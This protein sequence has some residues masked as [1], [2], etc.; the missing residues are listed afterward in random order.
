MKRLLLI[1]DQSK[2][3]LNAKDVAE[4]LGMQVQ[5]KST[6][7][8]ARKFLEQGLN[9]EIP[10]PEVIVLDLD[11]GQDSGFEL[12]RFRH[13][14][15]ALA[16]IPLLVWSV[17]EEQREICSLFNIESFVSKWQGKDALR[18]ALTQLVS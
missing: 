10:L 3:L 2:D 1:D 9:G 7:R 14:T 18:E 17:A 11:L 12:L 4:E 13:S 15:P 6:L 5:A 16:Q 8:D